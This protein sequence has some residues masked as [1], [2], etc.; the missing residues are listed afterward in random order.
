LSYLVQHDPE[1]EAM[2]TEQLHGWLL[3]T[4]FFFRAQKEGKVAEMAKLYP[5][6]MDAA[7]TKYL[8]FQPSPPPRALYP[9]TS[10]GLHL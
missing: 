5:L 2:T 3:L 1:V 6:V 4:A 9:K 10:K 8:D 7:P